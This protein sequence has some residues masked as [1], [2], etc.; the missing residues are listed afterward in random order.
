MK[1][2]TIM[3]VVLVLAILLIIGLITIAIVKLNNN[4]N[5]IDLNNLYS[6]DKLIAVFHGG[7]GEET[8]ETYIYKIDNGHD[9][10]GFA[11]K[12]TRSHTTSWGS[13]DWKSE[14]LKKGTVQW[15]DDI[16]NIAEKNHAYS[17][18]TI[19]NESRTYTIE[20]FM[21]MFLKN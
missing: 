7:V 11:Y 19:P 3:I 1:N 21:A 15:T 20:D 6:E 14:V 2:K 16:F 10:S 5:V 17:Y 9:N 18:V 12:N 8:Y 13:G 4:D